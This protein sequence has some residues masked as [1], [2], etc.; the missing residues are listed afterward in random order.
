M[1]K[2]NVGQ[3][4]DQA[5]ARDDKLDSNG[6][7]RDPQLSLCG[8]GHCLHTNRLSYT[9]GGYKAQNCGSRSSLSA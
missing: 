6:G 4:K 3:G 1:G 8:Q 9:G 2:I 5:A 7:C